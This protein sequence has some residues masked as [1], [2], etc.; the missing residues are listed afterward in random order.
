MV[1]QPSRGKAGLLAL[2]LTASFFVLIGCSNNEPAGSD[3]PDRA[4][5]SDAHSKGWTSFSS[6]NAAVLRPVS[7]D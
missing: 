5:R 7:F 2:A 1:F 3:G 6:W 4:S